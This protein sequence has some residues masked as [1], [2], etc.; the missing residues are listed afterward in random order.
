VDELRRTI[1]KTIAIYAT[2]LTRAAHLTIG[3][4]SDILVRLAPGFARPF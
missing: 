1:M 4:G 2:P 3:F